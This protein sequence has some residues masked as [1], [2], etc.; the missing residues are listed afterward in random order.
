MATRSLAHTVEMHGVNS[1]AFSADSRLLFTGSP[2]AVCCVDTTRWQKL[3]EMP[4]Q[5][6]GDSYPIFG[7]SPDGNMGAFT[8]SQHAIRLFDPATGRELG[9][10]EA[11]DEETVRF[12]AFSPDNGTLA[13][14]TQGSSIQLWDLR[15]VRRQLASLKLDWE[16]PA[17]SAAMKTR[18]IPPLTL[19]VVGG[20]AI[21]NLSPGD[22]P[23][24]DPRCSTNQIDLSAFYNASLTNSWYNPKWEKNDLSDL[25]CGLQ[26]LDNVAFD[27]RGVVQLSSSSPELAYPYPKEVTGIPVR[28]NCRVL[29]FLH[30]NGWPYA[31][32]ADIG[33]YIIH[34]EDG[35]ERSVPL[36]YEENIWSWWDLPGETAPMK[37]GTTLAWRGR[38]P[39]SNRSN[40]DLLLFH[41]RWQNPRPAVVISTITFRSRMTRCAPFLVALTAE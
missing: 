25:P 3:Y 30:A 36:I 35:V 19:T 1:G 22:F 10:F 8:I 16:L 41:F 17:L 9:T 34:Y 39:W 27:I 33:E 5:S 29:H 24:R 7:F 21:L 28:Q 20:S 11:P 31:A 15:G 26:T 37:P 40:T 2:E 38:N 18:P 13:V 6:T 12:V 14:A 23:P 32:G 4:R